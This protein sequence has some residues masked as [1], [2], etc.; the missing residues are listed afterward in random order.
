MVWDH[1]APSK[2]HVA[3]A[4]V[5]V[6]STIFSLC[7]LFV[8]EK[9]YLGEA[10]VATIY[11]LIVGP[12]CLNWFNPFSWG[13]YFSITLE[14]S[15]VLLCIEIVAVSVELPKKYVLKHWFSLFILLIPCMT[16]GWL[17]IGAFIYAIIPGLNFAHG[18]LISACITATDPILAQ[19]VV[20][21]GKFAKRVPAHL[22]NLLSAESACNDGVSVPF[23]YLALNII[24]HSGHPGEIAKDWI[25]VSV[26]YE[27]V[28]GAIL[29]SVIGYVGRKS[30]KFAEEHDL[31]DRE[32]FLAFYIM[33]AM[34]CAGFGSVLGVDDLLASFCCGTA[35]AWDGWFTHRTEESNVSTVIDIL[36]NMAYF[37]YF[38]SI[39]P[40]EEFNDT[41]LGLNCWRLICLAIVV[42][43]LRRL[44]AVLLTKKINPDIKN[45]KEA[46]FVGHFG[47]IGVG[48]VFAAIIAISELEAD[49]LHISHGPSINY[50]T[51]S[52]YYQ[53]IRIIWP[54]VCFLIVTSII[55]HGSSVAVL[56]LGKQLQTMSFT[57]TWTKAESDYT[58]KSWFNRL[59]KL[60]RSGTSFSLKRVD[61]M[62]NAP[63]GP[64][65]SASNSD[66]MTDEKVNAKLNANIGMDRF[67][68]KNIPE[69]S[70]VPG[71]PIGGATRKKRKR[72]LKRSKKSEERKA[73]PV[74]EILDL[75]NVNRN[76]KEDTSVGIVDADIHS[77]ISN[78]EAENNLAEKD[79]K[80][81]LDRI[82][83][84][85][86]SASKA[87]KF[88]ES[89]SLASELHGTLHARADTIKHIKESYDIGEEDLKPV[90]DEDGD[91]RIPTDAYGYKD[92]LI[93]EDQHGEVLKTV[94]SR[95]N[96]LSAPDNQGVGNTMTKIISSTMN[97]LSPAPSHGS[98]QKS[99][100]STESSSPEFP[101]ITITPQTNSNKLRRRTIDA[102]LMRKSKEG[103]NSD[104]PIES[105]ADV[106]SKSTFDKFM[107]I[108]D[109]IL[110]KNEAPR[111]TK[112]LHGYRV[113]DDIIIENEDGEILGRYK[114]NVKKQKAIEA[115]NGIDD[116]QFNENIVGKAL[117]H[118]GLKKEKEMI[119]EEMNELDNADLVPTTNEEIQNAGIEEKLKHFINADPKQAVVQLPAHLHHDS[120]LGRKPES[121]L[122]RK[123]VNKK[124]RNHSPVPQNEVHDFDSDYTDSAGDSYE[125]G[126]GSDD[127]ED[128]DEDDQS[129][130]HGDDN[131]TI[132]SNT[133]AIKHTDSRNNEHDYDS[134]KEIDNLPSIVKKSGTNLKKRFELVKRERARKTNKRK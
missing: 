16:A 36:L 67:N 70:G 90:V 109:A 110:F 24:L 127:D 50:P 54:T 104:K 83:S 123:S 27:C 79:F 26:L 4:V 94:K 19:A 91:L 53:L 78:H 44:P 126:E 56:T 84:N 57:M 106:R 98:R 114:V 87:S 76:N 43:F 82:V 34:L 22:R 7:S 38:G 48:A 29:G 33:L 115:A 119:D 118:F 113:N 6:F 17:I 21:K 47:P 20:G 92:T 59:P 116:K 51:N 71:K 89:N 80:K 13:N 9:L 93:I 41:V 45:W 14:I 18:L 52:E 95:R 42:L 5:A 12:H 37:V 60:E 46:F 39:I 77:I 131:I 65:D 61:T 100:Q 74:S 58:Q 128:D 85:M 122:Q 25:C 8:K 120:R 2:S 69:S 133:G 32:S 134:D 86:S 40:W 1:L 64:S 72:L 11:G 125:S 111:K 117:K 55:V 130:H 35:F 105:P 68:M 103:G 62:A 75:R 23:V 132:D 121:S 73:P 49:V 15:R 66:E 124:Q 101:K 102:L 129:Y 96:T 108:S 81:P 107:D 88:S 97:A 31:I 10:S 112:R 28:F 63:S 30:L 99:S 3:Y